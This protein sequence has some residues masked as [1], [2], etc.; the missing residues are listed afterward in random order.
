MDRRGSWQSVEGEG[1]CNPGDMRERKDSIQN[2]ERCKG[3]G[4]G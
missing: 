2:V 1:S 4:E 3:G